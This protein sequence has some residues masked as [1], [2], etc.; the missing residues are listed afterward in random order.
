MIMEDELL[1][2]V[3]NNDKVIGTIFKEEI[4]Q[5][6]MKNF[7]V[8]NAF[9]INLKK[10]VWIPK[11]HLSKKRM[12]NLL[13]VSVGGHVRSKE[14]YYEALIR[15]TK[16]ELNL[17]INKHKIKKVGYLSP[18]IDYTSAFS[19]VYF[20]YSDKTPN[21]NTLEIASGKWMYADDLIKLLLDNK[22][23]GK[24][25]LIILAKKFLIKAFL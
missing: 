2:I 7:R 12:P 24:S 6:K 25:D 1:D 18:Y 14:S 11:R 17:D 4:Y 5:K 9:L 13:D 22:N 15:E 10:Q 21:F 3:S 19:E 8:I 20:M 23:I 16:E